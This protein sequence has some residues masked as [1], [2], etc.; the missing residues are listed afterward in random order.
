[1]TEW[2]IKYGQYAAILTGVLLLVSAIGRP[3]TGQKWYVRLALGAAAAFVI[4]VS[5]HKIFSK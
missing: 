2:L 3:R 4:Y 5:I 1:M